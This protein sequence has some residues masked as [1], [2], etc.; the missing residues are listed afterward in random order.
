MQL[1]LISL[2]ME[3]TVAEIYHRGRVVQCSEMIEWLVLRYPLVNPIYCALQDGETIEECII[4]LQDTVS[5][6]ISVS[7]RD[8]NSIRRL[9]NLE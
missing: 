7:E 8:L 4:D 3:V 2:L 1:I 5:R 9:L 6:T